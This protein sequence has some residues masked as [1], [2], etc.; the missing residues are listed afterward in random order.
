MIG[1]RRKIIRI[2]YDVLGALISHGPSSP[3]NICCFAKIGNNTLKKI[4]ENLNDNGLII[5]KNMNKDD[6]LYLITS[7]GLTAYRT[8]SQVGLI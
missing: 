2:K 5:N 7:K 3:T 8:F 1:L 6:S 4:L